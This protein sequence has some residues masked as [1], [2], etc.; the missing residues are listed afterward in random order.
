M[1]I[2]FRYPGES[3]VGAILDDGITRA[4]EVDIHVLAVVH[5][6]LSA[7]DDDDTVIHSRDM[8]WSIDLSTYQQTFLDVFD[9]QASIGLAIRGWNRHIHHAVPQ[10]CNGG[11]DCRRR[12]GSRQH[13]MK[14]VVVVN[15]DVGDSLGLERVWC[16]CPRWRFQLDVCRRGGRERSGCNL[17]PLLVLLIRLVQRGGRIVGRIVGRRAD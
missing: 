9:G 14:T 4:A 13:D 7:R 3:D 15:G 1:Y 12:A 8:C 17:R 10:R 11:R 6:E 2:G 5:A 16:L